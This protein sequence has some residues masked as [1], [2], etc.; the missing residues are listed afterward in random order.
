MLLYGS[1]ATGTLV[2]WTQLGCHWGL[3]RVFRVIGY[4]GNLVLWCLWNDMGDNWNKNQCGKKWPRPNFFFLIIKKIRKKKIVNPKKIFVA[5]CVNK[6][7]KTKKNLFVNFC[8][9][10]FFVFFLPPFF[11]FFFFKA[12]LHMDSDHATANLFF[13]IFWKIKKKT[14][15]GETQP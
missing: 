3:W 2:E 9:C 14:H 5:C 12:W 6:K 4:V 10:V 1:R 13:L 11:L 15:Y 8:V 7:N